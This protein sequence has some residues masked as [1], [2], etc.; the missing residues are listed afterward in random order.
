LVHGRGPE[1]EANIQTGS[2]ACPFAT[3]GLVVGVKRSGREAVQSAPRNVEICNGLSVKYR[4]TLP[5]NYMG[6]F[7]P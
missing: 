7:L 6:L 3:S 2:L 5:L 1:F 4:G